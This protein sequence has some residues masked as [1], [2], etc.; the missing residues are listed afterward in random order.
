MED[1]KKVETYACIRQ[2]DVVLGMNNII[3]Y[4]DDEFIEMKN[5]IIKNYVLDTK[6]II[7]LEFIMEYNSFYNGAIKVS[8]RVKEVICCD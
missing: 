4:L 2:H 8:M 6:N 5:E 1:G 3:N 7:K